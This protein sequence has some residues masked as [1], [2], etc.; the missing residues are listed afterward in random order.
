[1]NTFLHKNICMYVCH[2]HNQRIYKLIRMS[3]F[4]IAIKTL[5]L[6]LIK[7][8]VNV[9]GN[10]YLI[11]EIDK[12]KPLKKTIEK[13]NNFLLKCAHPFKVSISLLY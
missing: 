2:K 10:M 8:K 11:I 12:Y 9:V 13:I 7:R 6:I 3:R 4:T 1:M 5:I